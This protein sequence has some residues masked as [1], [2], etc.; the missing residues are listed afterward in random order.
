MAGPCASGSCRLRLA[1]FG[2]LSLSDWQSVQQAATVGDDGDVGLGPGPQPRE[3]LVRPLRAGPLPQHQRRT[4]WSGHS[5]SRG[6][7]GPRPPRTR[8]CCVVWVPVMHSH[9][10]LGIRSSRSYIGCTT[11]RRCTATR[12]LPDSFGTHQWPQ[13][14]ESERA[15]AA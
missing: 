11:P 12:C 3:P 1:A 6:R 9:G 15:K 5:P 8:G 13:R 4:V 10:V 7:A 2:A 14:D